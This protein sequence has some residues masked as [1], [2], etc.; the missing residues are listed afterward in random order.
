M[1]ARF[2][3]CTRSLPHKAGGRSCA[4]TGNEWCV[5]REVLNDFIQHLKLLHEVLYVKKGKKLP[6]IHA[7]GYAIDKDG[8]DF[9][10][11]LTEQYEGRHQKVK[12]STK[13]SG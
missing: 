9:L 12:T 1:R 4:A 10:K 7:I 8:G 3:G 6:V 11:A 5:D 2:P 13:R